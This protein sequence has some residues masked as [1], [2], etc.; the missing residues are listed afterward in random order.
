MEATKEFANTHKKKD[1]SKRPSFKYFQTVK[2]FQTLDGYKLPT[3]PQ[4]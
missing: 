2:R 3:Q 4:H 1:S